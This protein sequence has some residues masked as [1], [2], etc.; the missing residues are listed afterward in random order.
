[1]RNNKRKSV[2]KKKKEDWFN[3][4]SNISLKLLVLATVLFTV[5][6]I[7]IL[8]KLIMLR[9]PANSS[10]DFSKCIYLS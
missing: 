3:F 9:H 7:G 2:L 6:A 8:Y 1:M 10:F 4:K 5:L